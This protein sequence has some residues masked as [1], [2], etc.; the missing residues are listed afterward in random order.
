MRINN[1]MLKINDK[2]QVLDQTFTLWRDGV[3]LKIE[4]NRYKVHFIEF[5][6]KYDIFDCSVPVSVPALFCSVPV[7]HLVLF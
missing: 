5:T 1:K 2:I 3:L 4:E 7:P 6:N